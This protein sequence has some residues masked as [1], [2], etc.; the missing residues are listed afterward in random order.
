M[1]EVICVSKSYA[2]TSRSTGVSRR[3]T[4][5]HVD[6]ISREALCYRKKN[7]LKGISDNPRNET[8]SIAA[9]VAAAGY[10]KVVLQ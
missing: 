7:R 4:M 8:P 1:S 9:A 10:L 5:R 2:K 6:S 3:L